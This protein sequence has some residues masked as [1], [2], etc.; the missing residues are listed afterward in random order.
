MP[1]NFVASNEPPGCEGREVN[2]ADTSGASGHA[3]SGD[4]T[5]LPV[6]PVQEHTVTK[7]LSGFLV[8][9]R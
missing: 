6:R 2:D 7:R 3:R 4:D 1:A 5:G 9:K 8:W